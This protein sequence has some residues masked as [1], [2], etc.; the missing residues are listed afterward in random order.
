MSSLRTITNV[1]REC[2]IKERED[3]VKAKGRIILLGTKMK[4]G[5]NIR[6]P[7]SS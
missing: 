1:K 4:K 6:T 2:V 3:V 5:I 7:I